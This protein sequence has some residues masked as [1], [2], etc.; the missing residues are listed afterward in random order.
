MVF[1]PLAVPLAAGPVRPVRKGYK[2]GLAGRNT[3]ARVMKRKFRYGLALSWGRDQS[4]TCG[5][6]EYAAM[7]RERDISCRVYWNWNKWAR[8]W[9]ER[10]GETGRLNRA[11]LVL[12]R[13]L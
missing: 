12:M 2:A 7:K 4:W 11:E 5:G 9:A 6:S 13:M 3:L 1:V 10:N 8:E